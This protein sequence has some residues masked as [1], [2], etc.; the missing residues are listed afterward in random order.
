MSIKF[1]SALFASALLSGCG[2]TPDAAPKPR[3]SPT[4]TGTYA[5]QQCGGVSVGWAQPGAERGEQADYNRVTVSPSG[6]FWNMAP[7]DAQTLSAYAAQVRQMHPQPFTAL[8]PTP[9]ADCATVVSV[10]RILDDKLQCRSTSSRCVEYSED[11]W[12]KA[13]PPVAAPANTARK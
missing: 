10:R 12:A 9:D 2:A 13:H 4:A 3:P 8:V 6:I 5:Q 1:L 7:I 11:A